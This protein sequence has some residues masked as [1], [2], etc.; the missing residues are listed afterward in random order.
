MSGDPSASGPPREARMRRAAMLGFLGSM[1][2][3]SSALAAVF[4]V[5][6]LFQAVTAPHE[7]GWWESS[8]AVVILAVGTMGL[9]TG[10]RALLEARRN[11]AGPVPMPPTNM[12][13]VLYLRSFAEDEQRGRLEQPT[14]LMATDYTGVSVFNA[15]LLFGRSAEEHLVGC[16]RGLGPVIAVDMPGEQLPPAGA[17]RLRLAPGDWQGPVRDLMSRARFVVLTLDDTPGALWEFVEA[18]RTVPPQR[19]LL[20]VPA[21]ETKYERFR[22]QASILLHE[23][24]AEVRHQTGERWTPPELPLNPPI[25]SMGSAST[26]PRT[27]VFGGLLS[28]SAS[29][30]LEFVPIKP[31]PV[32]YEMAGIGPTLRRA[33]RPALNRLLAFEDAIVQRKHPELVKQRQFCRSMRNVATV[34]LVLNLAFLLHRLKQLAW[35]ASWDLA[36]VPENWWRGLLYAASYSAVALL[37]R[38]VSGRRRMRLAPPAGSR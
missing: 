26:L 28:C 18:T 2:V 25:S 16:F 22:V 7:H 19:L 5:L 8:V 37:T 36:Q 9:N 4:A 1:M 6:A 31:F 15:L 21:S 12:Q 34:I 23:R 38:Y 30:T 13:F 33:V 29:R 17:R 3:S 24:A 27:M 14:P 35:D 10:Q 11:I 32:R 20:V